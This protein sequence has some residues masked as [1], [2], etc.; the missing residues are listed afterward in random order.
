MRSRLHDAHPRPA[1]LRLLLRSALATKPPTG[2]LKNIVVE[3]SGKH[4]GHFDVKHGGLL[5]IVNIARY[6]ALAAGAMTTS[7]R[8]RLRA[9]AEARTL[10]ETDAA[11]L[12][13]AFDL[14]S[15]LRLK[16]QIHAL[17]AGSVPDDS[18]NPKTLNPLTRRHLRDAFRAVTSV[19]KSLSS[20][21]AWSA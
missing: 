10:T 17:E 14:L 9:A 11:T 20:K 12:G 15:D 8:E 2:F 19:Q 16:H 13:E 4:A 18:I 3:H 21:L 1:L 5:P 7:T 6:A